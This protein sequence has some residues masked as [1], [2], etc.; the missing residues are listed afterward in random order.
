M[1]SEF[2][3]LSGDD[4]LTL[5][6]MAVGAKGVISVHPMSFRA[7]LPTW[8]GHSPAESSARR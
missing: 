4:S 5:P 7:R 3:I 8:C 2:D 1:G 6:F